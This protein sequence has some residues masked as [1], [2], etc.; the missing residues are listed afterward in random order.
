MKRFGQLKEKETHDIGVTSGDEHEAVRSRELP[1]MV[2]GGA[3][4]VALLSRRQP[5]SGDGLIAAELPL[6]VTI[7]DGV[8]AHVSM[9]R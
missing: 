1:A 2:T 7:L 5:K 4:L 8:M 3:A 6:M 9:H